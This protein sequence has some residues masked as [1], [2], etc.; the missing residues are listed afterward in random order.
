MRPLAKVPKLGSRENHEN[1]GGLMEALLAGTGI[2]AAQWPVVVFMLDDQRYALPLAQVKKSIRVVA[3]TPL[4][5]APPIV[6]GIMDLGGAVIP[7]IDI[8]K[9]FGHPSRDIRLS[10]H[11]IVAATQ[12]R[13]IAILVDESKGVV[14]ISPQNYAPAEKILPG[15]K[16]VD[17]A[18]TLMDGLVLIHDLERLLSLDEETAI[19]RVLND[20][21]HIPASDNEFASTKLKALHRQP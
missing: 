13:T 19:D 17:G 11:L 15:L 20:V 5:E 4:L 9:R 2:K 7:V 10:D 18:M 12:R 8:R 21:G 14:E 16:L 6:L 3:I 1:E